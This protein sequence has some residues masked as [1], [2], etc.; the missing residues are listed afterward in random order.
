MKDFVKM[1]LA[2]VCGLIIVV[3]I[4]FLLGFGMLGALISAGSGTPAIPKSGVLV[5][6]MSGFVIGEQSEESNPLS[7]ITG[8]GEVSTIGLWDAVQ[9]IN[10]AALDPAVKYIYLKTDGELS[11]ISAL[12]ELRDALSD[13]R[14]I[15]GKPIVSYI[16][17]PTTGGYYLASVS[18]KVYM[19]SHIGG[20]SMMTGVSSQM[21]FLGDLLDRLGVNVQLIR[22]GKYKSAGEMFVRSGSSAENREQNQQMVDSMWESMAEKI[23]ES[24]EI[25]VKELDAAIND[26]KLNLPQDF[27]ECGLVDELLTRDELQGKLAVLAVEDSYDDVSFIPF[28][29][30]VAVNAPV[31]NSKLDEI[32]VI[33]ADGE[34]V[35]GNG[36]AQVAGDRFASVVSKV[37]ADSTVKAVVLRVN[38][39]GGSVLASEKIRTEL[40]RLKATKP[41]VASYGSY[42]ASGGY[43]ISNGC[44]KIFTDATTL[45]G[46]IGVF[47][48]IPDFSKTAKDVL[49]VGVETVSSHK[50]GDMYAL[51]R[52]FDQA[53]YKYMTDAIETVYGRFVSLVA[54]SRSL[55]VET[56]DSIAQGRVWTGADAITV[57]LADEIGTLED[58]VRYAASLAGDPE[59]SD[60][61]IC[62]YPQPQS[63]M[64]RILSMVGKGGSD[65]SNVLLGSLKD[66]SAPQV[67][68]RMDRKIE[69]K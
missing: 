59:I 64:E 18:D 50:H 6:D 41:V 3:V 38:S 29:D 27:V 5:M 62:G 10:A 4:A 48:M 69:V 37:C 53:E 39:P 65:D 58:A 21:I 63:Q 7:S 56:V 34:I 54:E 44:D 28:A 52:P 11:D 9:A 31:Y 20:T 68:A 30:Y 61:N 22:H 51:I 55:P 23:A 57:H 43:W 36:K 8:G 33:Y 1:T 45:T 12:E 25:S 24:R 47:G 19:T 49:H 32:A 17:A 66:L 16:E 13:F 35:D 15:S 40:D 42:A 67:L 26:L 46:S 14:E 2:V 60:W